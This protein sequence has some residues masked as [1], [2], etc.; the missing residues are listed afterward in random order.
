MSAELSAA[1]GFAAA[2]V[3]TFI[4]TPLA[5]AVA[6]RTDFYDRPRGYRKH[7]APTPF[8]GGAAVLVGFLV[9]AVAVG[10]ATGRLLVMLGCAVVL[11]LLG[12][13][14]DRIGIPPKWR[15]LVETLAAGVLFAVGLG[16]HTSG[17]D[18][19]DFALT[20]LWVVG[21]VN[22]FNLM[23]NLDGACG[24]VGCVSATG[25]GVLAAIN[26]QSTLAGLSFAIA[27][28]CAVF[29]RWNLARP[30]KIFLGD[31][32]SMLIGFLVAALAMGGRHLHVGDA[33][34]LAGALMVG[35]VMLD[36]T[37]VSIS[38][39]RRHVS[40][41][42]GGRDHL[43][44]RLLIAL[45]SPRMVSAAL[46]SVQAVLCA[47]AITGE[48]L[49]SAVLAAV[50]FGAVSFG[51]VSIAVLDTPR[52]RPAEI[53]LREPEPLGQAASVPSVGVDSG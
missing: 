46:A 2:G 17:G 20:V 16:W 41:L 48:Q 30:A 26:G 1:T 27:G 4:A 51:I 14:D 39:R 44:H 45:H 34:L 33:S 37:L 43:T 31:G 18:G 38:R 42:T 9:G 3:A 23:D 29:L 32:G 8:L 52:W 28:A 19:I 36:T 35:V 53:A 11:W 50:S 25:I 15:L 24:T 40:L 12:T 49:G 7:K 47:L 22:A 10:V 6:C 21:L 13:I 5:I